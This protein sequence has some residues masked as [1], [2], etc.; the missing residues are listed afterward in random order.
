MHYI[1]ELEGQKAWTMLL[2]FS[3][4]TRYSVNRPVET[5]MSAASK[6]LASRTQVSFCLPCLPSELISR[7]KSLDREKG[8]VS[9]VQSWPRLPPCLQSSPFRLTSTQVLNYSFSWRLLVI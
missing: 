5:H 9:R 2:W 8:G 3:V 7:Y 1:Y 4:A 6:N